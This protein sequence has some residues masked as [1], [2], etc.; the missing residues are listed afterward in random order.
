MRICNTF[1]CS[2][3]MFGRHRSVSGAREIGVATRITRNPPTPSRTLA[4]FAPIK[5]LA[6]NPC[7]LHFLLT[8]E[9]L[10]TVSKLS[11]R[12]RN[13]H[14]ARNKPP[15]R[16]PQQK[17]NPSPDPLSPLLAVMAAN[18]AVYVAWTT[19]LKFCCPP[20]EWMAR[21][22]LL[23]DQETTRNKY[24]HTA[25]T[26]NFSHISVEHLVANMLA[27]SISGADL[28]MK[29]GARKFSYFYIASSY[30]SDF[31]DR[32]LFPRRECRSP[33]FFRRPARPV[34]SLGAS[35]AISAV[36]MGFTLHF[37]TKEMKLD[38]REI[39]AAAASLIWV[40]S[41]VMALDDKDGIGHGAHL[42][43]Y[44]FGALFYA[45]DKLASIIWKRLSKFIICRRWKRKFR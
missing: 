20:T 14:A 31:I 10:C 22:F 27:L 39:P 43:G 30:A 11:T 36:Q 7:T 13:R 45:A 42:G 3:L 5:N 40:L 38:D 15:R 9:L 18:L 24:P 25:L 12:V 21:H 41:D 17:K 4:P 35:G 16:P 19:A 37:P 32:K 28:A 23:S 33:S 34:R 8:S 2:W 29:I 1:L 44:I 6:H 26:A